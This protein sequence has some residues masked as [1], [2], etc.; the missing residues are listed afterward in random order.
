MRVWIA[1]SC[2]LEAGIDY[3]L[4]L[5]DLDFICDRMLLRRS[6]M[7]ECLIQL[8][9]LEKLARTQPTAAI[10]FAQSEDKSDVKSLELLEEPNSPINR[11]QSTPRM[12]ESQP[13]KKIAW[14]GRRTSVHVYPPRHCPAQANFVRQPPKLIGGHV[15]QIS[16]SPGGPKTPG[17]YTLPRS[18]E[19]HLPIAG[20]SSANRRPN[21]H[22]SM[23]IA[24]QFH[25]KH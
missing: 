22:I 19:K 7:H 14:M 10:Y 15:F 23:S 2:F 11:S 8:V 9:E 1:L 21:R 12:Q 25:P 17:P 13:G 18:D 20:S 5:A 24:L 6:T 16:N 3:G 4:D